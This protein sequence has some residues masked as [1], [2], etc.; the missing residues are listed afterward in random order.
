MHVKR[1]ARFAWAVAAMA[2]LSYVAACAYLW[3]AQRQLIFLPAARV[4]RTP[5]DVGLDFVD[6]TI[7]VAA[8]S[9]IAAWWLP[10]RAADSASPVLVYLHGNDGNVARELPRLEALHRQALPIL[11]MDYR[12]Y[13]RS[14]GPFPS[15]AQVYE[16]AVAA[17]DWL[18]EVR[19][20]PPRRIVVWGHSLG[21]AVAAELALRRGPACG[22]VLE[23]PFTSVAD[24]ARLQ[25]PWIPAD[26]LV[27]QRF[28][29]LRKIERLE[30]PI[31][32]V[33]GTADREVPFAMSARLHAEA[34]APKQLVAV[35][36]AG[37]EDAMPSGGESLQQAFA[38]LVRACT[39]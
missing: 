19:G 34:H 2:A 32:L 30:V 8:G 24:L 11:A 13:G 14:S 17:W 29:A 37:H 36:G 33:H 22:V 21:A 28:D 5:A 23:A 27:N 10:S 39:R 4:D 16:D 9:S 25:Y 12:G 1:M 18:V 38:E 20:I 35:D 15:E 31:L 7:P 6:V 26:W 3:F